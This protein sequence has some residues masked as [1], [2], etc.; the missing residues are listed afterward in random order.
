MAHTPPGQTRERIFRFVRE[1]L[2]AGDPPTVREVQE[3][4]GFRAPASAREQLEALVGEGRLA[5][6][7]GGRARGYRLPERAAG[8]A[9]VPVLGRVQAGALT[10]AIEEADGFVAVAGRSPRDELFALRV[11]G[12][13]MRDAAILDGD[14]VIVRRQ[15]RAQSGQIVVALVGDGVGG[16]GLG[17]SGLADE[18]AEVPLRGDRRA[19]AGEIGAADVGAAGEGTRESAVEAT[20]EATVEA[21]VK[22]LRLVPVRERRG[23][24]VMRI[25]LHPANPDFAPIVPPQGKVEILGVVVEVR[26]DL[27]GGGRTAAGRFAGGAHR[28]DGPRAEARPGEARPGPASSGE[29]E[30]GRAD[31]SSRSGRRSGRKPHPKRRGSGGPPSRGG[32]R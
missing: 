30:P 11:R 14:L 16:D 3:A 7:D 23:A 21:T 31:R 25:E 13:S 28:K 15:S 29:R 5:K 19:D 22:T 27:E 20:A 8:V 12:E 9:F 1:R 4:F 6:E 24:I 26:R 2:L 18:R 17:E 32:A 10:E